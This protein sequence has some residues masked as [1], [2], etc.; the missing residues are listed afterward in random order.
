MGLYAAALTVLALIALVCT[1]NL[2]SW[3]REAHRRVSE[4]RRLE[5][6]AADLRADA[7]LFYDKARE[8]YADANAR[9]I[10]VIRS[11]GRVH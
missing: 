8:A 1:W 5:T 3:A 2:A 7:E 10:S 4:I 11:E 9:W 6:E